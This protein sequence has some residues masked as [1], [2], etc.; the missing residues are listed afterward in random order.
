MIIYI[1]DMIIIRYDFEEIV[2]IQEHLNSEFEMKNLGGI[3][4]LLE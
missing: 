3:N 4:F 2:K 1:N